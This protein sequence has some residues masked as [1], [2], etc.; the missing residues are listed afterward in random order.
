MLRR[1]EQQMVYKVKMTV[2]WDV[3][4][5]SLIKVYRRFKCACCLHHQGDSLSETPAN[6]YRTSRRNIPEDSHFHTRRRENLESHRFRK[7]L[8][9]ILKVKLRTKN[10][11]W[12]ASEASEAKAI[13]KVSI[14]IEEMMSLL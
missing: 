4:P 12:I 11:N 7:Y 6:F 14:Y 10:V 13:S 9:V 1:K 3:A 2:F 5:C 8:I